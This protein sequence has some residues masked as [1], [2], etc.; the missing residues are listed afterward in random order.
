MEARPCA[1]PLS[2]PDVAKLL[3]S[4][5]RSK[6]YTKVTLKRT[7]DL[8]LGVGIKL[9]MEHQRIAINNTLGVATT[10]STPVLEEPGLT[11]QLAMG[12]TL[13]AE[14]QGHAV[15]DPRTPTLTQR[16]NL[17]LIDRR[18]QFDGGGP[19]TARYG[20]MRRR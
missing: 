20:P 15:E 12:A 1:G 8:G 18:P 11:G 9:A 5:C 19:H 6:T 3:G 10:I 13:G 16:G 2:F 14:M 7:L 4:G 17:V